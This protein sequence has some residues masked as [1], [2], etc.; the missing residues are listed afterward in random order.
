MPYPSLSL[1]SVE[2][3]ANGKPI[4]A[5][6]DCFRRAEIALP[7]HVILALQQKRCCAHATG[8][9]CLITKNQLAYEGRDED[10]QES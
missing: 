6:R 7:F 9:S 5:A 4:T 8:Y 10:V 3:F 2:T 1:R